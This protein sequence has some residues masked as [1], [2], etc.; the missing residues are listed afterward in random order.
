MQYRAVPAVAACIVHVHQQFIWCTAYAQYTHCHS[1]ST[2][3]SD[4][5]TPCT[6]SATGCRLDRAPYGLQLAM[7][8]S[9]LRQWL[10]CCPTCVCRRKPA[11]AP[12]G[13]WGTPQE[14]SLLAS[15]GE[16][17]ES[18]GSAMAALGM[19]AQVRLGPLS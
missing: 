9:L 12:A 18:M 1:H 14:P 2:A 15:L 19:F 8:H 6:V 17:T 11:S 7:L 4:D 5:N 3:A 13:W 16:F 10:Y